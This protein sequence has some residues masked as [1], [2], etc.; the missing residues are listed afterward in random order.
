MSSKSN[1]FI[2]KLNFFKKNVILT[3]VFYRLYLAVF[4][5][6]IILIQIKGI[7]ILSISLQSNNFKFKNEVNT[8]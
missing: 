6:A 3:L 1:D 8:K 4:I 5:Y 2:T 7:R